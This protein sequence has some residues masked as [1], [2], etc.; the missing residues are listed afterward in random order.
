[1]FELGEVA[2]QELAAVPLQPAIGAE[3]TGMLLPAL[4]RPVLVGSELMPA[5]LA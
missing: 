2:M 4:R 1:M 3:I 5:G